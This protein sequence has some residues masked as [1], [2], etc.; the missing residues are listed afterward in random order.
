MKT[1]I[2]LSGTWWVCRKVEKDQDSV[3]DTVDALAA[4][5]D[6]LR[7]GAGSNEYGSSLRQMKQRLAFNKDEMHIAE[8]IDAIPKGNVMSG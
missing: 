1:N 5:V 6:S 7:I 3:S 2:M 8:M 4:G